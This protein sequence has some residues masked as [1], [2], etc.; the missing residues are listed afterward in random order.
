MIDDQIETFLIMLS[1]GSGVQGL[2]SMKMS[3]RLRKNISLVRPFLDQKKINLV[4]I[5]KK[6]L[7]KYFIDPSNKNDKYLTHFRPS[8]FDSKIQSLL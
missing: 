2:S 3:T 8:D 4:Y 7:G 5:T 6:L 1:R